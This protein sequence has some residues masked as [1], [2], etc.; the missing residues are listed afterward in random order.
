M[1]LILSYL[2][3]TP[4]PTP[5]PT[6]T[7]VKIRVRTLEEVDRAKETLIVEATAIVVII[8]ETTQLQKIFI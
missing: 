7:I 6:P 4:T 5:T 1:K 3:L 2:K 8:A